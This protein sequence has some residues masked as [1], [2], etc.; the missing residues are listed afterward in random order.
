MRNENVGAYPARWP[1]IAERVRRMNGYR[2]ERCHHPSKPHTPDWNLPCDE[3]CTHP[4]IGDGKMRVLTCH[5]LDGDKSEVRLWNL[6]ALCQVCHLQIQGRV[7]WYQ[8]YA[9]PHTPWMQRHVDRYEREL[10]R[11]ERREALRVAA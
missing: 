2:C 10:V 3:H 4:G 7:A 6:A 1:Q 9:F 5:H 8:E 11:E